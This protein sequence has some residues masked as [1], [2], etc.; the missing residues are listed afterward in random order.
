MRDILIRLAYS[1]PKCT[2]LTKTPEPEYH[3]ELCIYRVILDA[4]A[5]IERLR[6]NSIDRLS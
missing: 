3:E 2:C 5:E 4:Q 1:H 6:A